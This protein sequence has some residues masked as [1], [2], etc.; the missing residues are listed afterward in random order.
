MGLARRSPTM[1]LMLSAVLFTVVATFL[2]KFFG[3]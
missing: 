2:A 1:E 3:E